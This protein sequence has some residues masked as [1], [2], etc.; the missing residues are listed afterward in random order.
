M[1]LNS[2]NCSRRLG[3]NWAR[4]APDHAQTTNAASVSQIMASR[5]VNWRSMPLIVAGTR[6]RRQAEWPL[7]GG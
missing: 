3:R 4:I 1:A 7:S 6:P 2:L 5:R